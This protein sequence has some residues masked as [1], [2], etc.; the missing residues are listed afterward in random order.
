MGTNEETE[1]AARSRES[2]KTDEQKD[3]DKAKL[4]ERVA[5]GG[6]P[7]A[8]IDLDGE[9]D[10]EAVDPVEAEADKGP[11]DYATM[12]A[13]AKMPPGWNVWFLR[14]RARHTNEPKGPDL[15]C[16]LWNLTEGDE[17]RAAKRA[18]GE[19]LRVIDEMAKQTIRFVGTIARE[20]GAGDGFTADWT[21]SLTSAGSVDRFWNRIGGKYR[22]VIKSLYLQ[23]HT[24]SVT[25][26]VDFFASCV[27]VRRA[28]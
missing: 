5:G 10:D 14:I 26:Q 28:G 2:T 23:N 3:A 9:D 18:R 12:P 4:L 15:W 6:A 7:D 22:H 13:G 11:P 21:G 1:T 25:D 27:S 20:G 17:K 19:G 24:L 16:A 8:V